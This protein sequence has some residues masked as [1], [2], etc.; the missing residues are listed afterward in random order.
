MVDRRRR[1]LWRKGRAAFWVAVAL[2]VL[3][4]VT[5]ATAESVAAQ[6]VGID[7]VTVT[8]ASGNLFSDI[9]ISAQSGPSGENPTG[10]VF[11]RILGYFSSAGTVSCLA[12]SGDTAVLSYREQALPPNLG[13][14]VVTLILT[15]NGGGGR[16]VMTVVVS[17]RAA[18][19][20]SI[21]TL[22]SHPETLAFGRATVVDAPPLPTS[23]EQCKNGGW[24]QYGFANQGQCI[25]FVN[26]P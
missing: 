25:K 7:S 2:C 4:P 1:T 5:V 15:D 17:P 14:N 10:T 13:P 23:K 6:S 9:A 19:D 26:Y 3:A 18:T 8:G 21:P 20:C 16:D 22:S 11:F 12:V 24:S